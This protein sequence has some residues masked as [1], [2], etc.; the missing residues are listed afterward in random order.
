MLRAS[1]A[2]EVRLTV[3]PNFAGNISRYFGLMNR[4]EKRSVK[5]KLETKPDEIFRGLLTQTLLIDVSL[6]FILYLPDVIGCVSLGLW[7]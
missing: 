5:L 6:F 2:F 1:T 4:F 7:T 3:S